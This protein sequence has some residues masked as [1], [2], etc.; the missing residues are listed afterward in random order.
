MLEYALSAGT[1]AVGWSGY[2]VS[3][4]RDLGIT[5]PHALTVAPGS[6]SRTLR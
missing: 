5:L 4:L 1:V 2:F 6:T 3:F